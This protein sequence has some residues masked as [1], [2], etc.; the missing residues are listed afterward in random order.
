MV[1]GEVDFAAKVWTIPATRMKMKKPHAVPLSEAAVALL[2]ALPNFEA[3]HK[4][5]K[6]LVFPAPCGGVM[7]DMTISAVM[8]RM[9]EAKAKKDGKGWI[10]PHVLTQPE[11]PAEEPQPRP[12]VPHGL[13]STFKDWATEAGIDNIQSEIAL[14]HRVG[15]EVEQR[16]RRTDLVEQRRAMMTAWAGFCRGDAAAAKVVPIRAGVA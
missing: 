3:D 15:N 12:A 8:K 2:K 7:S 11:D 4:D 6:A 5:P 9:H 13:R 1:F 10:D 16:Y 14:A